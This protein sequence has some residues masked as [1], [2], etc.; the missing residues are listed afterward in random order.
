MKPLNRLFF[1]VTP[2]KSAGARIAWIRD[3]QAIESEVAD[4]RLHATMGITRDFEDFP[5]ALATQMAAIGDAVAAAPADIVLDRLSGSTRSLALRPAHVLKG[6]ADL[7]GQLQRPMARA[8]MLR[9]EWRYDF[10]V[11]LGYRDGPVF[12]RPVDPIGWHCSEFVLIHS[13]AGR[14]KHIVL[15]RWPLLPRQYELFD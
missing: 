12:T 8:D 6:L 14:T 3:R 2:S 10:H 9:P 4:E 1:A 15:R 13:I 11:T 7:A 5:D